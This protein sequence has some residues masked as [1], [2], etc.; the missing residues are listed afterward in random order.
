MRN[1]M[2]VIVCT[3]FCFAGGGARADESDLAEIRE[4]AKQFVAAFNAGDA[5][6]IAALW[7]ENADYRDETGLSFHGR[8]AI[9]QAYADAFAATPGQK[10]EVL[11]ESVRLITP[12][13][14]VEDGVAE[15]SPLPPG[16]PA[17]GRYTA[18][19]VRTDGKWRLASVRE[20][21]EEVE[22]KY[23]HL[24]PL[25][26]LIGTWTAK[27]PGRTSETTFEWTRNKNFIKRTFTIK[28]GDED[29]TITK[30]TQLIGYDPSRDEIR[31]WLFD[32]ES[33]FAEAVWS[34]EGGRIVGQ[35]SCVLSDGST[36]QS[37]EI[38][39]RVDDNEFTFQSVN[40]TIERESVAD[41][42]L[43][44]AV[45]VGAEETLAQAD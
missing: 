7:A 15:V 13:L 23:A 21:R 28:L 12:D 44:T 30:G 36:A 2:M 3:A 14:A 27:S 5:D 32:S 45:R 25:E 43:I 26:W 38:L 6:A 29:Y 10:I 35:S 20:W 19:H 11:V 9:R 17:E 16:P 24:Q 41:G 1:L 33:G 18:T 37:T 34:V 22:S 39:T 4:T 40:R 42:D 8:D 31:S